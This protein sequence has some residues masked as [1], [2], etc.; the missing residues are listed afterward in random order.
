M[1]LN[2]QLQEVNARSTPHGLPRKPPVCHDVSWA[3]LEVAM[4]R[5]AENQTRLL[6]RQAALRLDFVRAVCWEPDNLHPGHN[7]CNASGAKTTAQNVGDK[8]LRDAAVVIDGVTIE[9][10]GSIWQT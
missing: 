1:E 5:M 2:G 7:A 8:E 6:G 10:A 4:L 3:A 9:W